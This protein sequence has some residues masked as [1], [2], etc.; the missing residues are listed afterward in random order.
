MEARQP[1]TVFC[2]QTPR[3]S[4]SIQLLT[5]CVD[6]GINAEISRHLNTPQS[7]F[8]EENINLQ[9]G[10]R[11]AFSFGN[12]RWP[13]MWAPQNCAPELGRTTQTNK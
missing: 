8:S 4:C 2:P 6:F 13:W 11:L 7:R 12:M 5:P 10:T 9:L 1:P 3:F